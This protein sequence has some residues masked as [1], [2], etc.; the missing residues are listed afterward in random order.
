MSTLGESIRKHRKEKKLTL[1]KLG[2]MTNLTHGYLSNLEN[3]IRTNPSP[4]VLKKISAAL[5]INLLDLMTEAGII[6]EDELMGEIRSEEER[7]NEALHHFNQN[8]KDFSFQM[9]QSYGNE[10][11]PQLEGKF[12]NVTN[13]WTIYEMLQSINREG[14]PDLKK[15]LTAESSLCFN[16]YSLTY[17]DKQLIIR[18]LNAI[19]GERDDFH[20]TDSK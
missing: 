5:E 3:N 12:R 19:F 20:S 17:K 18:I 6:S 15:I 16:G 8:Q 4:E 1:V 14:I 11:L 10:Q 2:E 9:L 13:S 7:I